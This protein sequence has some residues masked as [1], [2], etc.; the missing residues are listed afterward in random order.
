ME[1]EDQE[2][3]W[4]QFKCEN[5]SRK[6]ARDTSKKVRQVNKVFRNQIN[7]GFMSAHIYAQMVPFDKIDFFNVSSHNKVTLQYIIIKKY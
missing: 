5:G 2:K 4:L 1:S 7:Y 3:L 6:D